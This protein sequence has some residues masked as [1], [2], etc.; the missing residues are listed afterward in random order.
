MKVHM[1]WLCSGMHCGMQ[2]WKA[3]YATMQKPSF[4]FDGRNIVDHDALR[5]IGFHVYAI[6]KP[7]HDRI[8]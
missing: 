7:L 1:T 2:D 4:V 5:E 6:G 8:Y 3:L